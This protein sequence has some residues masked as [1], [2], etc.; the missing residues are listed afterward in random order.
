MKKATIPLLE[1]LRNKR[2]ENVILVSK[3]TDEEIK[4]MIR[5]IHEAQDKAYEENRFEDYKFH[6]EKLSQLHEA[7]DLK[8]SFTDEASD[9]IHW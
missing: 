3:W 1:Q 8:F 7:K 9:W 5:K 4:E 2:A 6:E